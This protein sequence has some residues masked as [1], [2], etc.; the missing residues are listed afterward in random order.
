MI[1][2]DSIFFMFYSSCCLSCFC[3]RQSFALRVL[4]SKSVSYSIKINRFINR[5]SKPLSNFSGKAASQSRRYE[6]SSH[7]NLSFVP[8]F[9]SYFLSRMSWMTSLLLNASTV[10]K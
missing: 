7:F 1:F 2:S 5:F 6:I 9:P 10:G 4:T 3:Y 8:K